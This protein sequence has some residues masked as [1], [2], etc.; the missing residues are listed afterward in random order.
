MGESRGPF[1]W[2]LCAVWAL[3]V[4]GGV[5]AVVGLTAGL[6]WLLSL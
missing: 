2:V 4:L 1:P 5:A 3:C 6:M